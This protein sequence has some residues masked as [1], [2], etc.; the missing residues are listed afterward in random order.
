MHGPL[1]VKYLG[2][3]YSSAYRVSMSNSVCG[4]SNI[5][6]G[7]PNVDS[8]VGNMDV[9]SQWLKYD[10]NIF[11]VPFLWDLLFEKN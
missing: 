11:V 4:A 6:A 5:K 7:H 2:N 3:S 9:K 10:L 8:V 1:N